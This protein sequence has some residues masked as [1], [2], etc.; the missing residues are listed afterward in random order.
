ME[1]C[2]YRLMNYTPDQNWKCRQGLAISWLIIIGGSL[3]PCLATWQI[4]TTRL[5]F[6]LM[7]LFEVFMKVKY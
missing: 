7:L 6:C 5:L 2:Y 1:Q 3:V 4:G